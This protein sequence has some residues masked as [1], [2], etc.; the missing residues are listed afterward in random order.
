MEVGVGG[1]VDVWLDDERSP[2]AR[3]A[4]DYPENVGPGHGESIEGRGRAHEDEVDLLRQ[5]GRDGVRA[6]VVGSRLNGEFTSERL[7]IHASR[8]AEERG[9]VGHIREGTD[10]G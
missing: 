4:G 5:E 9:S 10:P 8:D 3:R 1:Q 6:R 7:L 2:T